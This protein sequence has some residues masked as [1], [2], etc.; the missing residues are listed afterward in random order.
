M[1]KTVNGDFAKGDPSLVGEGPSPSP[2]ELSGVPGPALF[3]ASSSCS[4]QLCLD[5][6]T[7]ISFFPPILSK[8]PMKFRGPAV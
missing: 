4:F 3:F 5:V 8:I 2:F 1:S 6:A 7:E